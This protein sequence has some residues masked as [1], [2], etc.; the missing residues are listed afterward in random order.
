M[1]FSIVDIE[2]TGGS[3]G[4]R[5]T[6]IAAVKTDGIRVLDSFETLINPGIFIPKSIT[7]LTGITNEMVKNAPV[8]DEISSKFLN[9]LEGTIFVAHNVSFD[10]SIIKNHFEDVAIPFNYKKLCTVRLSRSIM[11]NHP[12]YSLGKLCRALGIQNN[13]RHRAMGDAEATTKLF[14]LLY[15]KDLEFIQHSL[16]QLSRESI[17][18]PHLPKS[19]F[20]AMPNTT[21]VYYLL[22]D[23][24]EILYIGKAKDMKKRIVSHFTETTR[25]KSELLRKIH[26]VSY[27]ETGNELIALLLESDEIKKHYPPYNKMQKQKNNDYCVCYYEGQDGILRIDIFLKKYQ[28]NTMQSFS[29]MTMAKDYLYMLVEKNKLCPKYTGLER[30]KGACYLGDICHLCSEKETIKSYNL[31]VLN[32]A[33]KKEMNQWIVGPGRSLDEKGVVKIQK[34]IYAGFGYVNTEINITEEEMDA[35]IIAYKTNTDTRRILEGFLNNP[36]PKAY[37]LI[38]TKN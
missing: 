28:K 8:F 20:E 18:P 22:G 7:L 32:S 27:I 38:K 15:T 26:H 23:K 10:Y 34:G 13:N 11:P 24:M 36:I 33:Q 30:T 17:L 5:I 12:S 19:E 2:T 37:Q 6:E 35:C 1:I 9:F 14:H 3:H 29:S 16:N 31:R 21:G 25:K 4:N